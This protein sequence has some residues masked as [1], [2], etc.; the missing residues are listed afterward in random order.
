[1]TTLAT[2]VLVSAVRRSMLSFA[3]LLNEA[4]GGA[5]RHLKFTLAT[6]SA[7]NTPMRSA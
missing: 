2:L 7:T 4:A 3:V 5:A 1:M 6:A